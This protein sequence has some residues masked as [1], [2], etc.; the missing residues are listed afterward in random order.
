M[1]DDWHRVFIA[2]TPDAATRAALAVVSHGCAGRR[3]PVDQLHMTLAFLGSVP[4]ETG[5]AL[6][7]RLASAVR[8]IPPLRFERVEHWPSAAHPRLA[9]A[10]FAASPALSAVVERVRALVADLGLP[11]DDHRPFRPHVT[12]ARMRRARE[13]AQRRPLASPDTTGVQDAAG[14]APMAA[15]FVAVPQFD[16]L[17]LFSST[18]DAHGARYRALATVPVPRT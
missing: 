3:V 8:P 9:V 12:L 13:R 6:V 2:L 14:A 17:V 11:V 7:A 16:A 4:A 15:A 18:L 10:S 5:V 1:D